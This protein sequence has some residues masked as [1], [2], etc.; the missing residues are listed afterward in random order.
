MKAIIRTKSGKEFA[1]MSVA[2][3]PSPSPADQ[4]VKIRMAAARINPVDLDL[5]KGMPLVPYQSPQIGG[6]DGAGTILETG[7][8]VT[9]FT[10]GDMV[11]FYRRFTDIGTWAEEI[12][13]PAADV[14][15]IPDGITAE[16][17][18]GIAL[19]ILTAWSSLKKLNTKPGEGILIHGAAG[20]VGFQAV[21]LAKTMGL[22]IWTTSSSKDFGRLKEAGA[23]HMVDYR[24]E[25][26]VEQVGEIDYVFDLV[27]K[28]VLKDSIAIAKKAVISVNLPDPDQMSNT[29]LKVPGILRMIMRL[30]NR[31][32]QKYAQSKGVRL[33][34]QVTGP[35]GQLMQ[36]ASDL[37]GKQGIQLNDVS[38]ISIDEILENG[39]T[40][41]RSGTVIRF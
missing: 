16:D 17:A 7:N 11:F 6:I 30:T 38:S 9:K 21:Q 28:S 14:A 12:T 2:D 40:G 26:F 23:T 35:D 15:T 29:G 4:E 18:G 36:E 34:G 5:M 8:G 37:L 33:I 27:G 31:R 32:L 3:L 24:T 25:N 20:G 13:I 1:N 41:T 19:P 10:P 39:M 22:E